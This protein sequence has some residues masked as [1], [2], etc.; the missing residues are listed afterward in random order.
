MATS[1]KRKPAAPPASTAAVSE[2]PF[3]RFYHS[4][5]L[6]QKT[7]ELLALIEG[8]DDPGEHG[9]ALADLVVEL[10]NS[11]M[12]YFFMQPL[13]ESKAGFIVQQSAN[14]G[15]TGAQQVIGSV[16]RKIIQ[17]M[18]AAQLVSVSGSIRRLMV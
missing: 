9:V 16:I 4:E 3:L 7:L 8:A 11:G 1:S 5:A 18:D 17:R 13:K 12:D 2:K 6:R 15:L 14:L 10:M